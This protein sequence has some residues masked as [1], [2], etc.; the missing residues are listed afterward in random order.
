MKKRNV[1]TMALS[2]AMVGVIGVGSTLAY[3]TAK[4]GTLTNTFEFAGNIVVDVYETSDDAFADVQSTGSGVNSAGR[5]EYE[6]LVPGQSLQKD[7]DVKLTSTVDTDLYVLIDA[8]VDG[9][10]A[11]AM[12]LSADEITANGWTSVAINEEGKYLYKMASIQGNTYQVFQTV[13]VPSVDLKGETTKTL[14]D[15]VINVYA[16]QS[17]SLAEGVTADSLAAAALDVTLPNA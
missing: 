12:E 5:I 15:I 4:D 7:V 11:L 6:N 2:L 13:T 3:L 8:G 9:T 10:S 1:M 17:D 14:N 16:V